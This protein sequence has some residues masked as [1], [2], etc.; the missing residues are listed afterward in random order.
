M[1]FWLSLILNK[2]YE[3]KPNSSKES[4]CW[5]II[6]PLPSVVL[7]EL[8]FFEKTKAYFHSTNIDKATTATRSPLKLSSP[9]LQKNDATS[10]KG[11][12]AA[13]TDAEI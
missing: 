3:I 11:A 7:V 10:D 8:K 6:T 13:P 4:S 12:A 9:N 2:T 1:I 5:N